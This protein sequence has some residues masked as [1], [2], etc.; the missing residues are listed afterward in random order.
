MILCSWLDLNFG[1]RHS[2]GEIM[3]FDHGL[4]NHADNANLL[5]D[6]A[7]PK[8]VEPASFVGWYFGDRL[9]SEEPADEML[10]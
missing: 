3:K 10:R 2:D 5:F 7:S 8:C 1:D 6:S 9:H 4:K